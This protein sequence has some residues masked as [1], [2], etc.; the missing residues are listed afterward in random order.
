MKEFVVVTDE[1]YAM[2]VNETE[3]P[4][5][6]TKA[7]GVLFVR[8]E[9]GRPYWV[10]VRKSETQLLLVNVEGKAKKIVLDAIPLTRRGGIAIKVYEDVI[11]A[12]LV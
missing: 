1:G 11:S 5:S 8:P 12:C 7:K 6:G 9:F 2:R 10:F 4:L 3:I